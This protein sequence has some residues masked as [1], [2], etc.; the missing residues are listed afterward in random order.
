MTRKKWE[1]L[2]AL[3]RRLE[4]LGISLDDQERLRRIEM[5]LARWGERECG[6]ERGNCIER[7]EAT[8]IPYNTYEQGDGKR[9]RYRIADKERGALKRLAAIMSK[10]PALWYYHQG[11]PRGCSLYVGRW[12]DLPSG[13]KVQPVAAERAELDS[14]YTRGVGVCV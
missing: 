10:Y 13:D 1:Q 8:G 9:G 2:A 4:G 7:D 3:S 12:A 11:D 14:Y 6:D 5:T